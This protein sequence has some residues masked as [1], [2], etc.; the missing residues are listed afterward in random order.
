VLWNTDTCGRSGW[1]SDMHSIG[2][3]DEG[4]PDA[5]VPQA[6]TGKQE[7]KSSWGVP[8]LGLIYSLDI[9]TL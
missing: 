6:H 4:V 2:D 9:T 1:G 7:F 3:T 8:W 5:A